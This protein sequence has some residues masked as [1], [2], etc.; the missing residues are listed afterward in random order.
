MNFVIG[1]PIFSGWRHGLTKNVTQ[2]RDSRSSFRARFLLRPGRSPSN[3]YSLLIWPG[4]RTARHERNR[5]ILAEEERSRA[6]RSSS[7]VDL[8]NPDLEENL[9]AAEPSRHRFEAW[10]DRLRVYFDN[11]DLNPGGGSGGGGVAADLEALEAEPQQHSRSVFMCLLMCATVMFMG[12]FVVL[13]QVYDSHSTTACLTIA[14][15]VGAAIC[16]VVLLG[17]LFITI[18]VFAEFF[19]GNPEGRRLVDRLI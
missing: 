18:L 7:M 4:I 16:Q 14:V 13:I 1:R 9:V 17:L 8:E 12:F 19:V 5:G 15:L 10:V 2:S 11:D 6:P 3:K